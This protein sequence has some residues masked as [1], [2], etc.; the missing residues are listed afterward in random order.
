[1]SDAPDRAVASSAIEHPGAG[2]PVTRSPVRRAEQHLHYRLDDPRVWR[3]VDFER[4][5]T[6]SASAPEPQAWALMIVGFVALCWRLRGHRR[7]RDQVSFA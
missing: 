2:S 1:M 3:Q 7:A 5:F 6:L 4:A